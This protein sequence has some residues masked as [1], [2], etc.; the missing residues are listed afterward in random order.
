MQNVSNKSRVKQQ[1]SRQI[2]QASPLPV[3]TANVSAGWLMVNMAWLTT[4]RLRKVDQPSCARR[5]AQ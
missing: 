5:A 1:I 4:H 3:G 2:S